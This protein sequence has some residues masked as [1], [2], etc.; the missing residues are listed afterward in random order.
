MSFS[1]V[2]YQDS[3]DAGCIDVVVSRE[4]GLSHNL[5]ISI[6]PMTYRQF[7]DRDLTLPDLP[8]FK[9]LPDPAECEIIKILTHYIRYLTYVH[10]GYL[11]IY[12]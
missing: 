8:Q 3:E 2:D 4:G 1:E 5:V 10:T 6:H 11:Q 12:N 9:Y 7:A